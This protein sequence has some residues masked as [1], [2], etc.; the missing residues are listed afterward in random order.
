[1]P[2]FP[3]VRTFINN[4]KHQGL[5]NATITQ[6]NFI[7]A[8][9]L[10][11]TSIKIFKNKLIGQKIIDIDQIGK[12]IIIHLDKDTYLTVHLRMEGKLFYIDSNLTNPKYCMV[13][14]ICGQKKLIY[15]DFRKFGTFNLYLSKKDL[16]NSLE[17]K[18]LGL[19]PF[20]K[21]LTANY[22]SKKISLFHKAIKTVL[23]DQSIIAGI[24]NIYADEILFACH[25]HPLTN[26]NKLSLSQCQNIIK[27]C[28]KIMHLAIKNSGTTISSYAFA[29]NHA[30][31]F[32]KYLKV[33]NRQ[34]KPCLSC[35]TKIKKIKVNGRGTYF[36]PNC[37]KPLV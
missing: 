8:K 26:A 32:Q 4:L 15:L 6:I 23:L 13:E 7:D 19:Q 29:P 30:G 22:L 18:K 37:Q 14:I 35:H 12:L 9:V 24:G 1:M 31:N 10:K 28:Q 2:E 25:I 5:L 36:C 27:Y 34:N 17:I 3:E 20:D 33:H 11:N 16:V 21:Q